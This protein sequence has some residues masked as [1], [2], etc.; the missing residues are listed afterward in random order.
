MR[1]NPV[2]GGRS[3]SFATDVMERAILPDVCPSA[4]DCQDVNEDGTEPSSDADS[5]LFDLDCGDDSTLRPS[6]Q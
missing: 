3:V 4:E 5:D 2:R 1:R 6:I